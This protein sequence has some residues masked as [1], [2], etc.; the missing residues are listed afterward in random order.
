M[1]LQNIITAT[2]SNL[3]NDE[4]RYYCSITYKKRMLINNVHYFVYQ[5]RETFYYFKNIKHPEITNIKN[6]KTTDLVLH[7]EDDNPAI[8]NIN[9]Q[10]REWYENGLL[11]RDNDLPSITTKESN[12]WFFKGLMHREKRKP[13]YI[14]LSSPLDIETQ[15]EHS[16]YK[17]GVSV[18]PYL[19][20]NYSEEVIVNGNK[21]TIKNNLNT[22]ITLKDNKLHSENDLPAIKT[23]NEEY[24]FKNG[25][26]HRKG[27]PAFIS[28]VSQRRAGYYGERTKWFVNG[29]YLSNSDI[30]AELMSHK[31]LNF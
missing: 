7:S 18:S 27:K 17:Y 30:E 5:K 15:P 19:L 2:L 14:N 12:S 3:L 23:F 10:H 6:C 24:W 4:D 29:K 20:L 21:T 22:E 25:F 16:F 26:I 13:A 1:N 8:I 9:D 11:H 28:S 31:I